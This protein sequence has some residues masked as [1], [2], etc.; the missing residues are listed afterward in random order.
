MNENIGSFSLMK[1]MNT[2]L[3]LKTIRDAGEI[4]RAQ[5]AKE[6]GLTPA[7]VTNLTAEL[8]KSKLITES[9]R[10]SS[11]G[12]R[13]PVL[14]T[15]NN[16]HHYLAS[17][18]IGSKTVEVMISNFNADVLHCA[19]SPITNSFDGAVEFIKKQVESF[20]GHEKIMGVGVGLH[21]LV[22]SKTGEWIFAPNL[23]LEHIDVRERLEEAL[24]VPVY[25]ENDVRLM[26]LGE[27]W[28]G[29]A[30][31]VQDFVM[32]YVGYGIGAAMVTGGSLYRG[33]TDGGGEIGHTVIDMDGPECS[34]GNHGCLQALAGE[35]ALL[36]RMKKYLPSEKSVLSG[37][38]SAKDIVNA[39]IAG[40]NLAKKLMAEQAKY[41]G[42][43]I[44]NL[45]NLFNPKL[46][47]IN[48]N[49]P[50][51]EK[52]IF[53]SLCEEAKKRTMKYLAAPIRFSELGDTAVLKGG[54]ALVLDHIYDDP[55]N[56]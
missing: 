14:L 23:G 40:D 9:K 38:S 50:Q 55:L 16:T 18:Y 11:T 49:I 22:D 13:K 48:S 21:G 39:A 42:C 34:C 4:S 8:M 35:Q 51:L 25:A 44:A 30:Q 7:T 28:F 46:V 5:V 56:R 20:P 3:I 29:T 47:V 10:G 52:A 43:G 31:N 32:M 17:V 15:I 33:V 45:T 36:E 41:L 6:T 2:A 26:T 24:G 27:M 12:G 19:A 1:R 54:I 37:G 53:S